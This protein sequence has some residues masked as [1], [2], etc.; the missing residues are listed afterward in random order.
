MLKLLL[1]DW[2]HADVAA[3]PIREAV[4][5]IEQNTPSHKEWDDMDEHSLHVVASPDGN[6]VGTARLE[7]DGM[8]SHL[9]VL[10]DFRHQGIGTAIV[11]EFIKV[12]RKHK[13]PLL[14]VHTPRSV[15]PFF[16]HNGFITHGDVF[17]QSG[18]AYI[19]MQLGL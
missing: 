5:I 17:M 12:G 2:P 10:K 3:K 14:K 13:F 1:A 8:L 19:E 4:F 7:S 16:S 11:E 6:A 15:A 9:A 18:T